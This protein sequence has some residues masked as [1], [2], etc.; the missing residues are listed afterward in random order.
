MIQIF[1]TNKSFDTKTAQ[2]WFKERNMAFQFIDIKEKPM[3][4]AE[5]LSVVDA[6]SKAV[7]GRLAALEALAD[8]NAK[9]YARFAYCDDAQKEETLLQ[10]QTLLKLPVCRNG[11]TAATCGLQQ[12]TWESW[13]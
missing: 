13:K 9:E 4:K 1:G 12:K 8:K 5:F 7:G 6:L 10:N 3:S 2:R 11:K